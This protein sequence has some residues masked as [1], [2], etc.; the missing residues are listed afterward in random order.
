M[1]SVANLAALQAPLATF[2][3]SKKH[4][5]LISFLRIAGTARARMRSCCLAARTHT[6]PSLSLSL[7]L[8]VS[9]VQR[10]AA[11]MQFNKILCYFSNFI[12]KYSRNHSA[13]IVFI[14]CVFDFIR[15]RLD[16]QD[17][18]AD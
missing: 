12:C 9:S 1:H 2:F 18:C 3:P 14:L 10:A 11:E 5:N 17:F 15:Q 6:P 7:S 13:D 8:C 4:P 16:Y